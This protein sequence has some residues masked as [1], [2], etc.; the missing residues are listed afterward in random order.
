ML[1]R[2]ARIA[3]LI[4]IA[5][6]ET[7]RRQKLAPNVTGMTDDEIGALI[8]EMFHALTL[9]EKIAAVEFARQ[10]AFARRDGE[11]IVRAMTRCIP[12]LTAL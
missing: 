3:V 7:C 12:Q 11:S 6:T 1:N 4:V 8:L 2:K 10:A 9:R 5:T